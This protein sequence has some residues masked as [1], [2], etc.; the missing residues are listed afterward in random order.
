M[1]QVVLQA[2]VVA[3]VAATPVWAEAGPG[4][5]GAIG[6]RTYAT[7]GKTAVTGTKTVAIARARSAT[8]DDG[9]PR[10]D[11]KPA[12]RPRGRAGSA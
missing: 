1:R 8:P 4:Q 10:P 2:L 3:L 11:R 9:A 5:G 12:R 7:T 6:A